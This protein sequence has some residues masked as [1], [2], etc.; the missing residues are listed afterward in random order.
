[1]LAAISARVVHYC[2]ALFSR[3]IFDRR[4]LPRGVTFLKREAILARTAYVEYPPVFTQKN[5]C[6]LY[7]N[8][9]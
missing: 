3:D 5:T 2:S 4:F 9:D 8:K 6:M 1:M 7:L